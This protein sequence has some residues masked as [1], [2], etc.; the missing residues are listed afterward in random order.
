MLEELPLVHTSRCEYLDSVASA[1]TLNPRRC[2]VYKE[3]LIYLFYGRPAYRSVKGWSPGDSPTLCPVCFV[4]KPNAI[5]KSVKRVVIC[6]S[7][8]VAKNLFDP[9]L[10]SADLADLE[11]DPRIESA[12]K[13]SHLFFKTNRD[14]FLGKVLTGKVLPDRSIERRFYS[15]LLRPGPADFDDRKSAIEVQID[16][17]IDLT[18]QLLFVVLPNEFL[19]EKSIRETIIYKWRCDPISYDTVGGDAPASYHVLVRDLVRRR[20]EEGHRL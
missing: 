18:D 15:L 2:D 10:T 11:L 7:G 19:E 8:A 13:A 14:Y 6:D 4:F 20:L 9:E 16:K 3:H 5:S 12:R 17:V 1:S